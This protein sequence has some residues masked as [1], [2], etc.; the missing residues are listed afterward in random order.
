MINQRAS[1]EGKRAVQILSHAFLTWTDQPHVLAELPRRNSTG[2][3]T[4][5]DREGPN[6][7][8]DAV[9]NRRVSGSAPEY[10]PDSLVVHPKAAEP[11]TRVPKM[12]RRKLSFARGIHHCPSFLFLLPDQRRYF[13]KN[14]CI[15]TNI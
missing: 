9:D 13:V 6:A 1:R 4:T 11:T 14:M 8:T 12:A 7:S 3:H 5:Q 2:V 15:Y 10:N